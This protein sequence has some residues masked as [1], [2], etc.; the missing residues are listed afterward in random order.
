MS[1]GIFLLSG[2]KLIEMRDFETRCAQEGADADEVFRASLGDEADPERFWDDVENNLRSGRIRLVFVS[3][4]IPSELRRVIEF[5][6]ERMSPT[7]VAGIEVKQYVGEGSLA[8]F[9]P[10]VVGRTEEAR[11]R[12]PP[13]TLGEVDWDFYEARLQPDR[14]ALVR[15]LFDRM[16][17][18]VEDRALGWEPKLHSGYLAFQRFGG[19][20]CA[21]VEVLRESPVNFWIRLPLPPDELRRRGEDIPDL[22][23]ELHG[24]WDAHNKLWRWEVVGPEAVPDLAPAIDLARR[25]QPSSGPMLVPAAR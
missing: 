19:Y 10:R 25:F 11:S 15:S 20:N 13:R 7:E 21:G 23:P 14:L 2:E 16:A 17:K 9:V 22:Y 8:T 24:R 1:G 3:D 4:A 5:L 6:N 18:A 12:K